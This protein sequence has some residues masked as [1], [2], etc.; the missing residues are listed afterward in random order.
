[1]QDHYRYNNMYRYISKQCKYLRRFRAVL[2]CFLRSSPTKYDKQQKCQNLPSHSRQTERVPPNSV[3]GLRLHACLSLTSPE[4]VRRDLFRPAHYLRTLPHHPMEVDGI[5]SRGLNLARNGIGAEGAE[6][7]AGV[8]GQC[9]SLAEL[10][11]HNND[12][13]DEGAERLVAHFRP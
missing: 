4:L 12:I 13:G 7:L 1:M 5:G 11:L 9:S 8:L 2:N 6:R 3:N 10:I